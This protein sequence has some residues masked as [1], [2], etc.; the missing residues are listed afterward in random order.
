MYA[1]TFEI[2]WNFVLAHS[3]RLD[4]ISYPVAVG[5]IFLINLINSY[6]AIPK[7]LIFNFNDEKIDQLIDENQANKLLDR[8]EKWLDNR[9]KKCLI[10]IWAAFWANTMLLS[11]A[12]CL[13]ILQ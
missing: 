3:L 9:Y 12:L 1:Y 2:Y 4:Q 6:L 5:F 11:I 13:H 8:Y 7:R 10:A